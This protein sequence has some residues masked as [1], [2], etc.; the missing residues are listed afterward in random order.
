[1]NLLENLP[2]IIFVVCVGGGLLLNAMFGKT[3]RRRKRRQIER[4]FEEE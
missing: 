4:L 3:L 2:L 1:M